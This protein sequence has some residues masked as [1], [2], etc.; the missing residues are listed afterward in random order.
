MLSGRLAPCVYVHGG[1]YRVTFSA[2]ERDS[3]G[4]AVRR[5]K[6]HF[7]TYGTLEAARTVVEKV[8]CQRPMIRNPDRNHR[9]A[10]T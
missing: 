9:R 10:G 8:D 6:Y 4:K 7:G 2:Y 3:E 5:V 1:N